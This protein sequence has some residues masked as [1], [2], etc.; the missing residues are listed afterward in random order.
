MKK[1]LVIYNY[2]NIFV[3]V[4]KLKLNEKKLNGSTDLF[5]GGRKVNVDF[6]HVNAF[7]VQHII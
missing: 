5:C 3:K 1:L 7:G 4:N 6:Y 2:I